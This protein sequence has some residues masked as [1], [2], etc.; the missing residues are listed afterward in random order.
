MA[1]PPSPNSEHERQL[2][3]VLA[4]YLDAIA[5]GARPDRA[6]LLARHP[7]LAAE[8]TEFF[9]NHDQMAA[10]GGPVTAAAPTG[11]R[12]P[13][14]ATI[15]TERRVGDY[16]ILHEIARGGMGV[17]Y[18]V[19]QV[20]LGREVALKMILS[21]PAPSSET[22]RRFR[23]EAEAAA[24]LDH[25]HI[26]PIYEVGDLAGRPYFTMKLV[27]GPSLAQWIADGRASLATWPQDVWQDLALLMSR[28]ARAV[29]HAHQ[30]GI[31]HR[32]LKPANILLQEETTKHTK[33][34]KEENTKEG[35]SDRR[36]SFRVFRGSLTPYVTD[37]GL[38]K[39]VE[40][41][42]RLTQSHTIVGTASY[43]APEQ[44]QAHNATLTTAADVYSLGAILYELLTGQP[45][46]VGQSWF[47]TLAQVV[48]EPPVPPRC[49]NPRVPFDLE[50]ICLKALQKEPGRRYGSAQDLALDLERWRNGE[51]VSVRPQTAAERAWRWARRNRLTALLLASVALLLIALSVGSPLAA[52]R[53]AQARDQADLHARE[54][55]ENAREAARLAEQEH[56]ARTLAEDAQARSHRLLVSGYVAN[57]TRA[58]DSGDLFASL[59]WYGEALRLDGGDPVREDPHRVRLAAVLR[60]CP[61]LVQVWFDNG[62]V[63]PAFSADGRR[64]VRV[65]GDA[66]RTWDVESG[67]AVAAPMK[68][69]APITYVGFSP[70]DRRV[71]TLA[72]DGTARVWNA[73]SGL[74]IAGPMQHGKGLTWAAFS[75]DGSRV[76]TVGTDRQA[77][78]WDA[79]T[80]RRVLGPLPHNLPVLFASFSRDGQR[81]VTCGGALDDRGGEVRV[82]DLTTRPPSARPLPRLRVVLWAHLTPDGKHVVA[83]GR[84]NTTYRWS[85]A[86]TRS[87]SRHVAGVRMDRNG[88]GPAPDRVL[89][90]DGSTAQ[91]YDLVQDKPLGPAL[92]HGGE[93]NLGTFSPDGRLVATAARDRTAR[94]WEAG[95]GKPLTPPLRHGRVVHQAVFSADGHRL[96]TATEDGVVRVW[97]LASR[98]GLQPLA[99]RADLRPAALSPDGRLV[100]TLDR[101]GAVWLR[102]AVSDRVQRGPWKL[103]RPVTLLAFAPD[104]RRLLGAS[105]AGI[106][107]WDVGSGKAVI[108]DVPHAGP[109]QRVLFTP[110]GS[111]AATVDAKHV[112]RVFAAQG[113]ALQ[114][115]NVLPR[116]GPRFGIVL[117]SDGR[118]VLGY[119]G[120]ELETLILLDVD[121][122]RP[123]AG[124]FRHTVRVNAA[125]VSP[126]GTRLAVATAEGS[127]FIWDIGSAR[128]ATPPLQHGAPLRLVG[129]SG[130]GRRLLT[131]AEDQSVRVW[132]VSTGQPVTP[133]LTQ[134]WPVASASLAA[135][136]RRLAV[137]AR[138]GQGAVW[139]LSPDARPV[140]DLVRLTQVLSGHA[141]DGTSGGLG[142]LESDHLRAR[143]R[144]VRDRAPEG[145]LPSVP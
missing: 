48:K 12:V 62:Q 97:E 112:L 69:A 134:D 104:G 125:A 115:S 53:I 82:W 123:R 55:E 133:L 100:A 107:I 11:S 129:F 91:V 13:S 111:R 113:G 4:E 71:V 128:P 124:P 3:E 51:A 7:A 30:R 17:V 31:L 98:D 25:P 10:L 95:S 121:S 122:G 76:A 49:R 74:P 84:G 139:D 9:A 44:A 26:V 33:H 37:F 1:S 16:E 92:L 40:R 22:L 96:L 72:A 66:A 144:R 34:T 50:A 18:R 145:A 142:P 141:V 32:D 59:A 108:R 67:E 19:R 79:A 2:N 117:T 109:V 83:G 105:E 63:L 57:G 65:S 58:L 20:S 130:D 136:A 88:P 127:A 27:E 99:P 52:W 114:S 89:K 90:K 42:I 103:S 54:A 39:C 106:G 70:D 41:D 75:P 68:H 14:S 64:V 126:D 86:G 110:D 46:F 5:A 135:D 101:D 143:S 73:A 94:V 23:I 28:V 132:D 80:G 47:E 137:R 85:L 21:R 120:L 102:D 29:H 116:K 43:M 77:H 87:D 118:A 61:R 36:S 78:V 93:V 119:R 81:L 140:E 6:G 56:A 131:V 15:L 38:A 138:D 45:P 24:Q 35:E 60:R 8:L